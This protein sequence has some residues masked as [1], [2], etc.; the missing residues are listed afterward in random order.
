MDTH[1]RLDQ[2]RREFTVRQ[3][4]LDGVQWT[5]RAGGGG[6]HTALLLT[7][8][9]G[10]GELT[11]DLALVLGSQFRVLIPDYP[12]GA[13]TVEAMMEGLLEL[14]FIEN[15]R[16]AV[17]IGSS[18][19][20]LVAQAFAARYAPYVRA[21]VLSH[22]GARRRSR[23]RNSRLASR[24]LTVMPSSL[25]R[26]L[27]RSV[28][29]RAVSGLENDAFW[30]AY[31]ASAAATLSRDDV[32][33]RYRLAADLDATAEEIARRPDYPV[34]IIESDNDPLAPAGAK[35]GL[36]ELYPNAEIRIFKGT[37]HQ[38]PILQPEEYA[39]AIRMFLVRE[40]C[41]V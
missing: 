37:G 18:F 38:T 27:L 14:F 20:G 17:V 36:R 41:N 4:T 3:F 39:A 16:D 8:A 33:S 40:V 15:S 25:V 35:S 24:I 5:Y 6:T 19:G 31:I 21:L 7:G 23:A 28:T 34:L 22:S 30:P 26:T 12:R 9:L 2:F 1:R 10:L 13:S 32:I 11:F 29:R